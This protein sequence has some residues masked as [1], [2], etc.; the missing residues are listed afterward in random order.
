M[1]YA[2]EADSYPTKMVRRLRLS[3]FFWF[4]AVIFMWVMQPKVRRCWT[5][6][7]LPVQ[8]W[9]GVLPLMLLDDARLSR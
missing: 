2:L 5:P 9:Y 8:S 3:S 6:G 4:G 7:V 1:R